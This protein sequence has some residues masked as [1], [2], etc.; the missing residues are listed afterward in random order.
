MLLVTF[1]VVGLVCLSIDHPDLKE[2]WTQVAPI[3]TAL[4]GTG[5]LGFGINEVRKAVENKSFNLKNKQKEN[6]ESENETEKL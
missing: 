4:L 2:L 3:I 5:G 1:L 6:L